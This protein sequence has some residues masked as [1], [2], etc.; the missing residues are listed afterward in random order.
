M[1]SL[2]LEMY[3]FYV[4]WLF[5]SYLGL[6][7]ECSLDDLAEMFFVEIITF[8]VVCCLSLVLEWF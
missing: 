6:G 2:I 5:A 8:F 1:L 3:F 7:L 4:Y